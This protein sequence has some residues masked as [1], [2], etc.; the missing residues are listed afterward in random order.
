MFNDIGQ[1]L[2]ARGMSRPVRLFNSITREYLHQ[3]GHKTTKDVKQSWL[4]NRIQAANQRKIHAESG[5]L[6][7]F[8]ITRREGL[9]QG[10]TALKEIQMESNQ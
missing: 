6:D 2:A 3:G 10:E 1:N 8:A 4:G 7:G 9:D 5:L